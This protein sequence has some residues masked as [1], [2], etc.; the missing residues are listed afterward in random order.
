MVTDKSDLH[1]HIRQAMDILDTFTFILGGR[2]NG[3]I[4]ATSFPICHIEAHEK[5]K[6]VQFAGVR[7]WCHANCPT[8]V[9]SK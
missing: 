3:R 2:A 1:W 9:P 6:D 8:A 7:Y 5:V 4:V